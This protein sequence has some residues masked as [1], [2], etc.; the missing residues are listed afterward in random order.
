MDSATKLLRLEASDEDDDY[1]VVISP[2]DDCQAPHFTLIGG[3]SDQAVLA[4][5]IVTA[6]N[7]HAALLRCAEALR[8]LM[9]GD[10]KLTVGIGGNPNYVEK[11]IAETNASLSALEQ[12]NG[13]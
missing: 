6:V 2:T 11:F 5:A 7:Q 12:S 10:D 9:G 13:G 3:G 1:N 4:R 8:A